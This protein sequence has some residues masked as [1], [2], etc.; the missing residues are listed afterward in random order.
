MIKTKHCW[1]CGWTIT[2]IEK[3]KMWLCKYCGYAEETKLRT[4]CPSYVE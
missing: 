1:N 3:D 2:W 4:H